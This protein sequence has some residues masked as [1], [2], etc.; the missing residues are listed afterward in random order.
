MIEGLE[1]EHDKYTINGELERQIKRLLDLYVAGNV[2][3]KLYPQKSEQNFVYHKLKRYLACYMGE[4]NFLVNV[5]YENG[6]G[7]MEL[8]VY[9]VFSKGVLRYSLPY[10]E[11]NKEISEEK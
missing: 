10:A 1:A 11:N 5:F 8:I 6:E 9:E 2:E 7:Y 4:Q 3:Y